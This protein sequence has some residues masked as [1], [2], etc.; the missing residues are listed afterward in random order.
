MKGNKMQKETKEVNSDKDL[1]AIELAL[2]KKLK[3]S[4]AAKWMV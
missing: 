1:S 3:K 2:L 4:D